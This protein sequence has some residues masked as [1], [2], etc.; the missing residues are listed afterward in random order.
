[1]DWK[2][3]LE[4]KQHPRYALYFEPGNFT[5]NAF[6]DFVLTYFKPEQK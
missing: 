3:W 2:L 4:L 1:M 5:F 6:Q